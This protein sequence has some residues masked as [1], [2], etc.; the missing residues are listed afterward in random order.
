MNTTLNELKKG[1]S[2]KIIEFI[3]P[4]TRL[5]SARFGIEVGQVI[6]CIAKFGTVVIQKN[7]QQIAIGKGL[8]KEILVKEV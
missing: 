8:S 1:R 3:N 2:A 6:K 5:Q 7:Q 4:E